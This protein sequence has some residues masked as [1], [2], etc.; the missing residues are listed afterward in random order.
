MIKINLLPQ[1][2]AKRARGI[3]SATREPGGKDLA[4]GI[5]V[6]AGAAAIVFFAVD[7]PRRSRLHDLEASN[8]Q[9]AQ[10]IKEKNDQLKGFAEMKKAAEDADER[11]M[12][13]N[14]LL[15]AKVVPANVLHELGEILTLG[16][17]PTMTEQMAKRTGNGPESDPN[18]RFDV[19]WDPAH[20]WVTSFVDK[21]GDFKLEGGAQ[22]EADVTQLSLR[23]AASA[24]FANVAPSHEERVAD[25]DSG[26]SYYRFTITGKVAY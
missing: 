5:G 25:K 17:L 7:Q 3:A 2:R 6:L 4:I 13:I 16:H 22:A 20:V 18:R 9:L 10:Q 8:D 23:L 15:A 1:K 19:T 26:I 11:A 12:G 14:R 24:Y 21:S